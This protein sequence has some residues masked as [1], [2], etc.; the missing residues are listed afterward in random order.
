[1]TTRN[2]VHRDSLL[3]HLHRISDKYL[4]FMF[5]SGSTANELWTDTLFQAIEDFGAIEIR[6][7]PDGYPYGLFGQRG[8]APGM[9]TELVA[10]INSS[11]DPL[12]QQSNFATVL[13]PISTIGHVKS[14]KIGPSLNWK[15]F[16]V[17]KGKS[18]DSEADSVS[19]EIIGVR[20]DNTDTTFYSGITNGS[21]DL[22]SIDAKLYPYLRINAIYVDEE[23]RTPEQ[24]SRWTILYDGVPEGTIQPS[25][26]YHQSHDTIQEGDSIEFRIAYQNISN[27]SM[28]SVLVL[29]LNRNPA[30]QIDTFELKYHKPLLPQDSLILSY[31]MHTKGL[32]GQ[33]RFTILVNPDF[34]QLEERLENNVIDLKYLVLKDER[35]PLLDVVFD[36][37]HILDKDIVS[38]NTTITMS[39]LDENQFIFVDDPSA[40]TA[41]IQQ[42]NEAGNPFGPVDSLIHTRADVMF[43]PATKPGEKAILEFTAN[44][45]ESGL[46]QLT[47]SVTDASGNA[48]SDL[49]Y[50]IN[51][52][53]IREAAISNIYPYPNPFTTSMKF[54]YTLTGDQI[55]DYMK[56]Q[57]LTVTGKIVR[58]ITQDELGHI[59]I[60]NN[61]SEFSW[62]GTDEFGD[63]LANGVYLYKVVAKLNGEDLN[64]FETTGDTFFNQGFGKIYLMR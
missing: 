43:Y 8:L 33:N 64:H 29:A 11:A 23:N 25:I 22:S 19:Y 53:V 24:H 40:F 26:A 34:D 28:D 55:P 62:D 37:I 63:Q 44:N 4:V 31:K 61:I 52:R 49:N 57:I 21:V 39:V 2:D 5:T 7:V 60:G 14:Q 10:N 6:N 45:L 1:M 36:G 48:S 46:Y 3:A 59:K 12:T 17:V 27:Y 13:Y 47:V 20:S 9:A 41:H 50:K 54:V 32:E 15:E 51:F 35:N 42:V 38:P 18:Y 56:I 58:E 16:Y 30:N